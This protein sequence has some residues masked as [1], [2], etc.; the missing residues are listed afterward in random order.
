[1]TEKEFN[2]FKEEILKA[3]KTQISE[4][5]QKSLNEIKYGDLDALRKWIE[6]ATKSCGEVSKFAINAVGF[7]LYNP[8]HKN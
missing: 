1:M 7:G 4:K 3:P 6:D 8:Q 2:N 5:F